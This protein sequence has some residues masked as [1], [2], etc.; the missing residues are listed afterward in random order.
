MQEPPPELPQSQPG[1]GDPEPER[2]PEPS[3]PQASEAALAEDCA[4]VLQLEVQERDTLRRLR[5][6]ARNVSGR[7][8][9]FDLPERC[10][11]GLIAFEGLGADYDYYGTCSAGACAG[12]PKTRRITLPA[13]ATQ[14]ITEAHVDTNG[15]SPCT[16]PLP[17]GRYTVRPIRPKAPVNICVEGAVLEVPAPLSPAE[18]EAAS[19]DPYWCQHSSECVLSC[20]DAQGCCGDPCGC[21][22][23]INARH[24]AAY[25]ASYPNTCSR[26]PCPA[27]GCAYEPA[28]SAVCRNGRCVGSSGPLGF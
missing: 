2:A 3:P 4:V 6:S 15:R 16:K 1:P 25:E 11:H 12:W 9:S 27:M 20:P 5:V 13:G 8:L 14:P 24:K 19:K 10:P 17:P 22:H 26:P 21:R 23:A 28:H 7:L 18:R